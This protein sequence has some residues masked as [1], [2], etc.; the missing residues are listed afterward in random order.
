MVWF[1]LCAGLIGS[2]VAYKLY[3]GGTGENPRSFLGI[4]ISPYEQTTPPKLGAV[5]GVRLA[6]P[7]NYLFFPV[8]Y[9]GEDSW[10]PKKT[11]PVRTSESEI[12]S[13]SVYVQWP[14]LLPRQ[15]RNEE[16]Y[17]DSFKTRGLRPHEWLMISVEP[18]NLK[19]PTSPGGINY[20]LEDRPDNYLGRRTRSSFDLLVPINPLRPKDISPQVQFEYRAQPVFDLQSAIPVGPGTEWAQ[21]WNKA[22]YWQG[23]PGAVV[24]TYIQCTRGKNVSGNELA[25]DCK[26]SFELK[27]FKANV[28]VNYTANLLPQWRSIEEQARRLMLSFRGDPNSQE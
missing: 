23:I 19:P 25:G 2:A 27:E 8:E 17:Q 16:S 18:H 3:V 12:S 14:S 15:D 21:H 28:Q 9:E 7:A 20:M 26:H 5:H 1:L 13:F 24:T 4:P 22:I 10:A 6:I 11:K